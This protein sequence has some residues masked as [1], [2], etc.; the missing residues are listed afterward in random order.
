MANIEF[1]EPTRDD[2]LRVFG[3]KYPNLNYYAYERSSYFSCDVC[4]ICYDKLTEIKTPA[5]ELA[6]VV[7]INCTNDNKPATEQCCHKFHNA[8]ISAWQNSRGSTAK[9][10]LCNAPITTGHIIRRSMADLLDADF[11][12]TGGKRETRRS[13]H[14]KRTRKAKRILRI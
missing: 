7:M 4:A 3:K 1:Q 5:T 11:N 10:P 2:K 13:K 14:R 6:N 12:S 9:C 8:C